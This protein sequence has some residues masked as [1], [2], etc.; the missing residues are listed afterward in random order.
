MTSTSKKREVQL[1]T[2]EEMEETARKYPIWIN[3]QI[4]KLTPEQQA[5][6]IRPEDLPKGVPDDFSAWIANAIQKEDAEGEE[7]VREQMRKAQIPS[8][9]AH[10]EWVV[11]TE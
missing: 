5:R 10:V 9:P 3:K 7:W 11:K 1:F 4:D 6:A 2:R 8:P